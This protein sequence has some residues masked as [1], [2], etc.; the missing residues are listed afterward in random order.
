MKK[1]LFLIVLSF[2]FAACENFV[3]LDRK[4]DIQQSDKN[5]QQDD[6]IQDEAVDEIVLD[7]ETV[8]NEQPDETEDETV[9]DSDIIWDKCDE[10]HDCEVNELC[11]KKVGD[12]YGWGHCDKVPEGCD[13]IYEPVCGCNDVTYANICEA[14]RLFQNA[15]YSGECE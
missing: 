7:E 6:E 15:K 14:N 10:T 5:E 8:D 4:D 1:L 13:D 11:V 12:C 2:F 9:V 3:T